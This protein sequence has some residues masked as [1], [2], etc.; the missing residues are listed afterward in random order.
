M[1][2]VGAYFPANN[3]LKA[4]GTTVVFTNCNATIYAEYIHR[5]KKAQFDTFIRHN[6]EYQPSINKIYSR[7]WG[8]ARPQVAKPRLVNWTEAEAIRDKYYFDEV[9]SWLQMHIENHSPN[10][11]SI[12]MTILT[13]RLKLMLKP[14]Q[15][16][17]R[18]NSYE[19]FFANSSDDDYEYDDG[20]GYRSDNSNDDSNSSDSEQH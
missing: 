7:C 2:A 16:L 1:F 14:D 9:F 15:N 11:T 6:I 12:L 17:G 3:E 13:D 18:N 4:D 5:E 19:D 10:R 8:E 20:D